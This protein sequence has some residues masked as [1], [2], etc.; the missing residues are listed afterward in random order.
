MKPFKRCIA[1][2]VIIYTFFYGLYVLLPQYRHFYSCEDGLAESLTAF[3]FL[4]SGVIGAWYFLKIKPR[5][6]LLGLLSGIGFL[7]FLDEISFGRSFVKFNRISILGKPIDSVHDIVDLAYRFTLDTIG[8]MPMFLLILGVLALLGVY[9][10]RSKWVNTLKNIE[11][12][13]VILYISLIGFLLMVSILLDLEI[14]T[15]E[16]ETVLMVEEV[17]ELSAA[18]VYIFLIMAVAKNYLVKD[19]PELSPVK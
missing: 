1:A 2:L 17:A 11:I 19:Q 12:T 18:V 16:T 8:V 15:D 10:Y 5:K 14:F 7:G 9:L 3:C 6:W 4:V 13:P